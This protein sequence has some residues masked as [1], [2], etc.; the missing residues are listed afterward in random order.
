MLSWQRGSCAAVSSL[1]AQRTPVD[2]ASLKLSWTPSK[3]NII[4][5]ENIDAPTSGQ[6]HNIT[7]VINSLKVGE[8]YNFANGQPYARPIEYEGH[9]PQFGGQG[10]FRRSVAEWEKIKREEARKARGS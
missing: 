4:K 9:S 3:G 10:M 2:E 1:I 8:Q 6:R 7:A 5:A